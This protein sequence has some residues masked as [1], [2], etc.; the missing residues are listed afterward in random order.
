MKARKS[1]FDNTRDTVG[2]LSTEQLNKDFGN[3]DVQYQRDEMLKEYIPNL[4]LCVE[5]NKKV[6]PED[7]FVIVET[8]TEPL[9]P[10]VI[11]TFYFG[12][13]TCPTPIYDQSIYHYNSKKEDLE[14]LWTIPSKETCEF[15]KENALLTHP[16]QR[17][18]LNFVLGFYDGSLLARCKQLNNETE[19][20]LNSVILEVIHD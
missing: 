4:K 20:I 3:I 2:K 16:Q 9:M 8:K 1:T 19:E 13:L 18:L 14:Y 6:F 10:N 17:Q 5:R 15:M 7:F 11:R 12:R